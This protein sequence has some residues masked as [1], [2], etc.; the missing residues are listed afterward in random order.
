MKCCVRTVCALG[1]SLLLAAC[2]HYEAG[3]DARNPAC[4]NASG[5][6]SWHHP[7]KKGAEFRS[8]DA[9]C[10]SAAAVKAEAA[11]RPGNVFMIADETRACLQGEYGWIPGCE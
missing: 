10:R 11:G 6:V 1:L 2:A 4:A 9:K 8:D 5:G 7:V 3:Y